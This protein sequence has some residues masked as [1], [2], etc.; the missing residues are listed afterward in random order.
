MWRKWENF[1]RQ[2]WGVVQGHFPYFFKKK[3]RLTTPKSY[4]IYL[5]F[6]CNST[7]KI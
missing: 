4:H 5:E 7:L 1:G 2:E 6:E 3:T